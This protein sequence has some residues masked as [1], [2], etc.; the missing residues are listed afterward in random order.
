MQFVPRK[1]KC[2]SIENRKISIH[3]F[4][5]SLPLQYRFTEYENLH[6]VNSG[7]FS[8]SRELVKEGNPTHHNHAFGGYK[9]AMCGLKQAPRM[10][11]ESQISVLKNSRCPR[12]SFASGLFLH[13]DSDSPTSK[14]RISS[15]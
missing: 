5:L 2:A 12:T 4:F 13:L 15:R 6:V 9:K 3:S 7:R 10:W 8:L 1:P 11:Q 14:A